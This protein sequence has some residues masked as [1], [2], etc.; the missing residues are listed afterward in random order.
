MTLRAFAILTLLFLGLTSHSL[1]EPY[2][3]RVP[4]TEDRYT[5]MAK[6]VRVIDGDTIEADIDLGF[7]TWRRG[8][9]LRLARINAPEPKGGTRQKG[10]ESA[11]WLRER[12]QGKWVVIRTIADRKGEDMKGSFGRYLVE[13]FEDGR[14]LND[15]LV[16][17]GHAEYRQ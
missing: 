16:R 5:Y 1:S 2:S 13:I 9:R 3:E 14:N 7:H 12:I 4:S 17:N 8:E 6:V 10:L 11:Q 15:L